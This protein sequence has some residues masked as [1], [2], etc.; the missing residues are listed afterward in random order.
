MKLEYEHDVECSQTDSRSARLKVIIDRNATR[1]SST[2]SPFDQEQ[3]AFI[4]RWWSSCVW[5]FQIFS[6]RQQSDERCTRMSSKC[7][8]S[9]ASCPIWVCFSISESRGEGSQIKFP[10][11]VRIITGTT[12]NAG[13]QQGIA[14]KVKGRTQ[15][16]YYRRF[17]WKLTVTK[18]HQLVIIFNLQYFVKR[19]SR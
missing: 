14:I 12:R 9:F 8:N 7:S 10:M 6:Y 18:T 5:Y 13:G 11:L 16:T 1:I 4:N 3:Q 19:Q 17:K 2:I 15:C